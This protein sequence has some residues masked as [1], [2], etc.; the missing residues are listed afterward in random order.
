MAGELD[1]AKEEAAVGARMLA[2]FGIASG[3]R[4]S[5]G[6]VSYRV[7]GEPDKFVV[8]GRGYRIDILSRMR[9]EDMVVCDLEG[10]WVDGPPGSLQCSEVKIHSCIYKNRPDVQSVT[11]VHPDYTVLMTVFKKRLVPMAQEGVEMVEKELPLYPEA[12]V[13]NSEAEGQAV[14]GLL[15]DG[16]AV[17][18]FGHGAVTIGSNPSQSV[19]R[20]IHLEHQAR[21]NYLA[22][23]AGGA[24]HPFIPADIAARVGQANPGAEPHLRARMDA[25]GARRPGNALWHYYKEV[26]SSN[27]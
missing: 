3:V 27:M 23:S 7:P 5:L 18:L 26:L 2:E 16:N 24:G 22:M 8:K 25:G 12:K 19:I 11:H 20:M 10:N 17:L 1:F 13:I 9:P 21:L 6:H 14:A 4:A 15:G